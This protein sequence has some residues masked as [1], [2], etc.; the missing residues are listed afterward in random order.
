GRQCDIDCNDLP[1]SHAT[2][3]DGQQCE[4][5]L[6]EKHQQRGDEPAGG[7]SQQ[8]AQIADTGQLQQPKRSFLFLLRDGG[9][10]ETRS[11]Q[12]N[13]CQVQPGDER[14]EPQSRRADAAGG[15]VGSQQKQENQQ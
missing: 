14:E 2:Q 9:G 4:G 1:S 10:K 6:G 15:R 8:Q 3:R 12:C 13:E 11:R 7:L 5:Q